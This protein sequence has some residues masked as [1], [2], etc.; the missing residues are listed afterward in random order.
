MPGCVWPP[1]RACQAFLATPAENLPS[2]TFTAAPSSH[3]LQETENR[4]YQEQSLLAVEHAYCHQMLTFVQRP[5]KANM[6]STACRGSA[7]C[8]NTVISTRMNK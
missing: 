7:P 8:Q 5:I 4:L 1:D 6:Q 2:G 3:C